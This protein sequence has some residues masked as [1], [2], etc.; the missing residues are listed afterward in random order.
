ERAQRA[1]RH[2]ALRALCHRKELVPDT[3][4]RK[5]PV[6]VMEKS[7]R[8]NRV[9]EERPP[10]PP[11]LTL[12]LFLLLWIAWFCRSHS[13]TSNLLRW[14]RPT[15]RGTIGRTRADCCQ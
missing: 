9:C 12:L 11:P 8:P 3:V 2:L 5:L 14:S 10:G 4:A 13:T 15:L 7:R 6:C 1:G